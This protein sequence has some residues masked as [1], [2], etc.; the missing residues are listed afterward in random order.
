[1]RAA[2]RMKRTGQD[3][4]A[5]KRKLKMRMRKEER[6]K[7][8]DARG[9]HGERRRQTD[10]IMSNYQLNHY[11]R[12]RIHKLDKRRNKEEDGHSK[13]RRRY[14]LFKLRASKW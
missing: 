13:N 14:T 10:S 7:V 2:T 12:K 5:K 11:Q 6:R 1:M 9:Q 8:L 3:W 4:T